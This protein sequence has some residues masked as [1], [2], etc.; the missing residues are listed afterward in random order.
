[1]ER[2]N[3]DFFSRRAAKGPTDNGA[4]QTTY[5]PTTGVTVSVFSV[6]LGPDTFRN[7]PSVVFETS[8]GYHP[9]LTID[10]TAEDITPALA[11]P[12]SR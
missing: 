11:G 7:G 2:A 12:E 8:E 9:G 1:M 3:H 10:G 4:R 5:D 6:A